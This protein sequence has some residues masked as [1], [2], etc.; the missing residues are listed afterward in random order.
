MRHV[1]IFGVAG[2]RVLEEV[3][4]GRT[5]NGDGLSAG[6]RQ[7]ILN[8]LLEMTARADDVRN[9]LINVSAE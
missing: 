1:M 5:I 7:D 3:R 4:P 8:Y 9:Y 2:I 6:T